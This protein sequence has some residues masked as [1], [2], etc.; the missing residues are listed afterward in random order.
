MLDGR[1]EFIPG[2]DNVGEIEEECAHSD[3]G[4]SGGV[5]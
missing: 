2:E 4:G 1:N 5:P 3:Q